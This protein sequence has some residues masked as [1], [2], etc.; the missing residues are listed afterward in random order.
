M[1]NTS[2]LLQMHTLYEAPPLDVCLC[3]TSTVAMFQIAKPVS[4][5]PWWILYGEH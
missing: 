2:D 4:L 3:T 5:L 1:S